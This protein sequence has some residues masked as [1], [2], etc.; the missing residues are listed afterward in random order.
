MLPSSAAPSRRPA[1]QTWRAWLYPLALL[2]ASCTLAALEPDPQGDLDGLVA[3]V[4]ADDGDAN[5]FRHEQA[6]VGL[7]PGRG[8]TLTLF[9]GRTRRFAPAG[10]LVLT[11]IDGAL[12]AELL[13]ARF[14]RPGPIEE[15]ALVAGPLEA[16]LARAALD[17]RGLDAA[18]AARS[19]PARGGQTLTRPGGR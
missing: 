8:W 5:F 17:L 13:S 15:A 19:T 7:F 1:R 12:R 11:R 16:Y 18:A 6:V 14:G 3:K 9:V 2:G 4:M 10:Y